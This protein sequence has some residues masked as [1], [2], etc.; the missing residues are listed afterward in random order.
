MEDLA[1]ARA[2]RSSSPD[3]VQG[4][5]SRSPIPASSARCMGCRYQSAAGRDPRC[6][7]HREAAGRDRRC[8]R[9][10]ADLS[11]LARIRPS[12]DRRR[13]R[14]RSCPSSRTAGEL[15]RRMDEGG[16]STLGVRRSP[17]CSSSWS[18]SGERAASPI[19]CSCSNTRRRH[20]RRQTRNDR[21]HV[22]CDTRGSRRCGHRPVRDRPWRRRDVSRARQLVGTR[23]SISIPIAATSIATCAIRGGP[24]SGRRPFGIE[25]GRVEG[26]TGIWVGDAKLAAI[27]VR[28]SAGSRATASR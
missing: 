13:R 2:R 4:G 18:R 9:H 6:R 15:R 7:R 17:W 16:R 27:G 8:D 14:G 5:P 12:A 25:A 3:D 21:S 24:D 23:S 1:D 22:L 11:S 19:S 10:Q 26:L 20:A 28:I